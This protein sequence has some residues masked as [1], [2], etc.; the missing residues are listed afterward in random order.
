MNTGIEK[1]TKEKPKKKKPNL[2]DLPGF[3]GPCRTLLHPQ[4]HQLIPFPEKK[5]TWFSS[6]QPPLQKYMVLNK[7]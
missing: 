5:I 2:A 1:E 3:R 7:K 4:N 6:H